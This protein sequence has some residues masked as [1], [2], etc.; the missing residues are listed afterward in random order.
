M[1]CA[2]SLMLLLM[3]VAAY[4]QATGISRCSTKELRKS[5]V[6]KRLDALRCDNYICGRYMYI[7]YGYCMY[8]ILY[9][10]YTKD[11]RYR[12][13]SIQSI[14]CTRVTTS[15]GIAAS[16]NHSPRYSCQ[17][18]QLYHGWEGIPWE[19]TRCCVHSTATYTVSSA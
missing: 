8:K 6:D 11:Q 17:L 19:G 1:F 13:L 4:S 15:H 9:Y 12:L 16:S 3:T 14:H 10:G 7:M 5:I 2:S 18:G